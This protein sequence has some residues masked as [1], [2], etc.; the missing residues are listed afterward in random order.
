MWVCAMTGCNQ[1]S[2][3]AALHDHP[4]HAGG[5]RCPAPGA[6]LDQCT[7]SPLTQLWQPPVQKEHKLHQNQYWSMPPIT[8]LHKQT[9]IPFHIDKL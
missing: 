1:T 2:M 6:H 3:A 8:H 7:R 5:R 9:S 4:E